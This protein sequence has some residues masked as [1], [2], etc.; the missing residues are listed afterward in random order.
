M[1]GKYFFVILG[2]LFVLNSNAQSE[3]A[4]TEIEE[5]NVR[6]VRDMDKVEQEY[7]YKVLKDKSNNV[8]LS[9]NKKHEIC[10]TNL[11]YIGCIFSKGDTIDIIK[12]CNLFGLKTSP[13]ANGI[14]ILY[15]NGKR[16]GEYKNFGYAFQ[17]SIK[18]GLLEISD[19]YTENDNIE[20]YNSV[21]FSDGIPKEL[22]IKNDNSGYGDIHE[23]YLF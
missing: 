15:K 22:F 17:V 13:H 2:M 20:Y 3:E 19:T 6:K 8:T 12:E 10:K 5:I 14:I 16:Y 4:L 1:K 11:S 23:L 9:F 7:E 21:T 18:N